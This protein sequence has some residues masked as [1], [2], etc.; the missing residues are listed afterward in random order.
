VLDRMLRTSN[1]KSPYALPSMIFHNH[2]M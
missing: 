1:I 2:S